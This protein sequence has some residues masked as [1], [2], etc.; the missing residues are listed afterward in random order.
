MSCN[1]QRTFFFLFWQLGGKSEDMSVPNKERLF[2]FF[3]KFWIIVPKTNLWNSACWTSK[4]MI[5]NY[6]KFLIFG[7]FIVNYVVKIESILSGKCETFSARPTLTNEVWRNFL[8]VVT[9]DK[10]D[11]LSQAYRVI[12]TWAT[13]NS[14]LQHLFSF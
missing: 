13:K 6:L 10:I 2:I 4:G 7:I 1:L 5:V 3:Q 11:N 9:C 14:P 8:F 12:S